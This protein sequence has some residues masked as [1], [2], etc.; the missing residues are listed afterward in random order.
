MVLLAIRDQH[1]LV[2][3]PE[4]AAAGGVDAGVRLGSDD[5]QPADSP[6][7]ENL[8][9]IGAQERVGLCLL[10]LRIVGSRRQVAVD[11]PADT[12]LL[13]QRPG[14]PV[15]LHVDHQGARRARAVDQVANA[16][17]QVLGAV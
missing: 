6:V 1:D 16:L 7:P 2:A 3:A 15:V 14:W 4:C 12:A 11:L 17:Q 10:D 8:V 9:R 13:N 5:H